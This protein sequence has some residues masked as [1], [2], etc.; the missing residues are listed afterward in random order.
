MTEDIIARLRRVPE[1]HVR[2][3]G[4]ELNPYYQRCQDAANEIEKLR[5]IIFHYYFEERDYQDAMNSDSIEQ[6]IIPQSWKDAFNAFEKEAL[7][8]EIIKVDGS[9][10]KRHFTIEELEQSD[11]RKVW[12]PQEGCKHSLPAAV[13]NKMCVYRCGKCRRIFE[14]RQDDHGIEMF[15]WGWRPRSERW[16]RRKLRKEAR[17]GR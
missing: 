10:M 4:A 3:Y 13:E 8:V 14:S 1:S 16:L 9:G 7:N 2:M 12:A 11:Y 6:Y 17:R 15:G 5:G